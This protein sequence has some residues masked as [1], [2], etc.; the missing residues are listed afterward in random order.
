MIRKDKTH[1]FVTYERTQ[2]VTGGPVFWTVPTVRQRQ[3]DFSQTL[4]A[5]GRQI[6]IYDPAT[7]QGN[8]RQPFPNNTI[9]P[10]RI[11]PVARATLVYWPE[12]DRPG[13]ITGANNFSRNSRPFL[14]RHIIVAR[15]DHQFNAK[16][17]L[18][19]RYFIADTL[20]GN[21]GITGQP[22]PD[23]TAS[24]TDQ[25]THNILGSWTNNLRPT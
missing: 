9:P 3:G 8:L 11:D 16:N 7:T 13:T 20:Q 1:F 2:Q 14:N 24:E 22:E 6:V 25:K 18:M 15:G 21:P 23:P 17:Q 5:Q 19:V 12:P 4:N 10:E